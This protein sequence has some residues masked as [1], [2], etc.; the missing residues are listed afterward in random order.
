MSY[1][2]REFKYTSA[3]GLQLF[4]REY[5]SLTPVGTVVCLPGLTRN[6]RDFADLAR[7]LARRYRVLTPDLRGRGFSDRDPTW[8]NYQPPVY[9]QDVLKLIDETARVPVVVIGTSLGGILAMALAAAAPTRIA[10]IVLN[11]VGPEINR[12]GLTRIGQYVGLRAPPGT[13]AEAVAQAKANYQEA[14]PDLGEDAWLAYAQAC[15]RENE[16]GVV[17]ADYDPKIGDALRAAQGSSTDLSTIWRGALTKPVLVIRG[18]AS[19][20]LSAATLARMAREKP[21]LESIE[22]PGR[23]HVPLL[24]ESG[25]LAKIESFLARVLP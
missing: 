8:T 14:Y 21:D 4:C 25:V 24:N 9:Y 20:I 3:D 7:H 1:E 15:Y 18:A 23:G 12:A 17:V 10:G 5:R 11:D 22:V 2:Y 13:W 19:D 16:R 6:S